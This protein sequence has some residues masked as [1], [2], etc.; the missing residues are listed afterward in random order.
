MTIQQGY[1]QHFM[2]HANEKPVMV[3]SQEQHDKLK[4]EGWTKEYQH[5]A[6]PSKRYKAT[7][8]DKDGVMQYD[9]KEVASQQEADDLGK[10]WKD[11]PPSA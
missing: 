7:V 9:T 2:H 3:D 5:Q 4:A 6:F 1:P 11:A 8:K 10:G